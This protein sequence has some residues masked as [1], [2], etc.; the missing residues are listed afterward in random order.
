VRVRGRADGAREEYREAAGALGR[1]LAARRIALVFGGA[2][3][4]LMGAIADAAM[5]AGG[6]AVGVIPRALVEREIAHPE[7]TRLHVV[8]SMHER[9]ALMAELCDV[10]IALPGGMGTLEE[11]FEVATWTQLG[12]HAKPVGLLNVRGY[13][14][15]LIDVLDRAAGEGF[16]SAEHR[17]IVQVEAD[18]RRLLDRL[19]GWRAP[20]TKWGAPRAPVALRPA[21]ELGE[22]A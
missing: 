17:Q 7:L 21:R 19:E 9:K 2:S 8:D 5:S 22:T 16:L 3:V 10:V 6:E 15:P 4:G 1:E 12:L 14:D 11:L 13:F 18:H 20:Q